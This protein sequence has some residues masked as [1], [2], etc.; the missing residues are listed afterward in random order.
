M[1]SNEALQRRV[2][3]ERNARKEAETLLE[4]KSRELY[5]ANTDLRKLAD[6]MR[7]QAER[8]QAIVET[9]AE[10]IITVDQQQRIETLNPAA[11]EIFGLT[12]DE[13]VGAKLS[14]LILFESNSDERGDQHPMESI[15]DRVN[16]ESSNCLEFTGLR[17]DG[18]TF[19][20][21]LATSKVRL[22]DRIIYTA[23]VRDITER[24]KLESQ[25]A[26]AQKMESLGQMAAGLAHEINTPVQYIRDN[27]QFLDSSF[28]VFTQLIDQFVKLLNDWSAGHT[29][30]ALIDQ[31][32]S[33]LEDSDLEFLREEIPLAIRQ[34]RDGA[35]QIATIVHAMK[36][37]SPSEQTEK[38]SID[39]NQAIEN[40]LTISQNR[41]KSVASVEAEFDELLP[42]VDCVPSDMNQVFM[43]LL[44][45]AVDAI[46]TKQAEADSSPPGSIRV[47]TK[48]HSNSAE[49][50]IRDSGSG[51][52]VEIRSKVFDPFF[53]TKAIGQGTGQGL[54]FAYNVVVEKHGGT[55]GFETELGVGTTFTI[56]LPFSESVGN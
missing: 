28:I 25:L 50:R 43:N 49:I 14:S 2:T 47:T 9:A 31:I 54:T 35:E 41:W 16:E 29:D 48:R 10:G 15:A 6:C 27:S 44:G 40:T 51:I 12:V 36:E 13:A 33:T 18:E 20:L 17:S 38:Q 39:L 3:R 45:N 34:T 32:N 24:K 52:P 30:Q 7:E 53:T 4:E 22:Y 55:I 23:L 8:I 26:H 21:E 5:Q 56:R 19:P 42:S 46:K 1:S 11:Q 37:F